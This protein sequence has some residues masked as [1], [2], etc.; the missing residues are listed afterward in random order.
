MAQNKSLG[1][2]NPEVVRKGHL[3]SQKKGFFSRNKH[4]C[5]YM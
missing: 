1:T 5:V 4:S 3:Q 2:F